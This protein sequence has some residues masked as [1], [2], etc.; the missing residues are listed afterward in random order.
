MPLPDMKLESMG[1]KTTPGVFVGYHVGPG[2]RWSGDYLGADY[3]PFKK[4][5][6]VVKAK[7]K[8]HRAK[9]A[10]KIMQV[11]SHSPSQNDVRKEP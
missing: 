7:V 10:L 4:D 6:D 1:N 11:N 5:G 2:G 3:S 9:E 8:I